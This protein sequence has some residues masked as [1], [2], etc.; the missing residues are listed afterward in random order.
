M[1][2]EHARDFWS[3]DS[4]Y[5]N[6]VQEYEK[7]IAVT[8]PSAVTSD[9]VGHPLSPHSAWCATKVVYRKYRG[10]SIETFK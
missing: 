6:L 7:N 1:G 10:P 9:G 5:Q 3:G 4:E 2:V 8:H